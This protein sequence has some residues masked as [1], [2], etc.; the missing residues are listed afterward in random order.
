MAGRLARWFRRHIP[1]R[2][3]IEDN[4][5]LRPIA[6]RVMAPNLWRMTRRSVPRGVAL[7]LLTG[8]LIPLGQIPAAAVLA[9]PLRANIPVAAATTFVTN[10][11]TMAP[12]WLLAYQV[13]RWVLQ[14]DQSLPGEPLTEAAQDIG[15]LQWIVADAGPATVTG[16]VT[17]SILGAI[18]GFFVSAVAWRLWV[19]R[20]WKRRRLR[21]D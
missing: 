20:K 7:G 12:L 16:L 5:W 9:F 13:G 11:I 15:W 2:E 3:T 17:L 8:I 4:R 10:P 6:H 18:T 14:I 1:T 21:R 19:A